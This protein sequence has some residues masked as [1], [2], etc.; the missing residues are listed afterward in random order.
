MEI[1]GFK[2]NR[3]RVETTTTESQ[4]MNSFMK[5]VQCIVDPDPIKAPTQK[6]AK[7]P[8]TKKYN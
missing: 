8:L 3:A 6:N 2:Q 4:S 1:D 7:K 5:A